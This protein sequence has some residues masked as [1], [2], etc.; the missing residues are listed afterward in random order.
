MAQPGRTLRR[1][2]LGLALGCV[3]AGSAF[4]QTA[5]TVALVTMGPGDEVFSRF[6]HAA[7]CVRD[8]E[9]P[10]G[11]CYNYGTADFST[12]G[13]LTWA[14][15]RGRGRFWVS[16]APEPWMVQRYGPEEDRDVWV[17][18]LPLPPE[19]RARLAA[20]LAWDAEPDHRHFVYHHYRDNC[21][22][23]LRD[24]LDVVTGGALRRVGQRPYGQPWRTP[25]RAGFATAPALLSV[26]DVVLGRALD[27]PMS[28]WEAMFLPAV[29]RAEV[30]AVL[31]VRPEARWR[32]QAGVAA[33]DPQAGQ[34]ALATLAGLLGAFSAALSWRLG[35]RGRR[36][37][38]IALGALL[39]A[40]AVGVWSLAAVSALPE[41][42]LNESLLLLLPTDFVF[43]TADEGRAT[44][45]ARLRVVLGFG[46]LVLWAVGLLVQPLGWIVALVL[47]AF[48]PWALGRATGFTSR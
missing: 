2:A 39:G 5:P 18:T 15:L 1:W 48:A 42:R 12:P 3:P 19:A 35:S 27:R 34:R 23:R 10:D 25:T 33:G 24:H 43:G 6:G 44:R 16:V 20:R 11:R 17:Q 32:R 26:S 37:A 36:R 45:Y 38:R 13:P 29:L 40:T 47:G 8:A 31:E 22:T 7:L 30:R 41:L 46:V 4:A 9:S 28:T 14:V 21:T